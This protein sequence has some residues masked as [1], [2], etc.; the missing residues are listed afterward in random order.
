MPQEI[1]IQDSALV[2][3]AGS[4]LDEHASKKV[5]VYLVG[6]CIVTNSKI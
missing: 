2:E 5:R 4:K 1:V 3:E 6:F